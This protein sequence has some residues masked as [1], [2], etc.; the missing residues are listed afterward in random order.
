MTLSRI[1]LL[2]LAFTLAPFSGA[3]AQGD[4]LQDANQLFR[5][6]Q[7]DRAMERVNGYLAQRPKDARG[8]FLKGLILTEQ[9]KPGEAIKVFTDLSQDFP[10]LPEPYNNLAVLYAS[11]GAY[12]K[13]RNSLEMAIRTHPSY[14]TAHENLGDIYAKMASQAYDKALQLDR[15]NQAAAGKLNLIKDLF[16]QTSTAGR[17]QPPATKVAAT[18]VEPTP[19]PVAQPVPPPAKA[20]PTPPPAQAKPTPAEP[21][22]AAAKA[23]PPAAAPASAAT[24]AAPAAAATSAAATAAGGAAKANNEEVLKSVNGWA[25]AWASNDVQGYLSYYAP[26]FQTPKGV[27]RAAWESERKARIAKPRKIEVQVDS[28]K[29]RFDEKNRAVVSFRQQYKSGA[30]DVTSM[31]TLVMIR[32]G[33]KWLIQQERVGS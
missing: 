18:K 21:P 8:R 3:W 1:A 2:L 24:A 11:Q 20:A 31:K 29:V 30:L 16:S 6:G 5:Q 33:D 23:A 32:N 13:A 12:D 7:F 22:S 28:P 10:E 14:A 26:D 4:P 25:R 27:S 15:S 9:N 17:A 19:A